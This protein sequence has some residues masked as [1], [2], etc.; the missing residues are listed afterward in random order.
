MNPPR[1]FELLLCLARVSLR[2]S[3]EE[4]EFAEVVRADAEIAAHLKVDELDAVFDLGA[5]TR[6]VDVVFDR[7]SALS[8]RG[9]TIY[10]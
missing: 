10:A 5:Y 1:E 2:A 9:V 3:D 7:L 8:Q 4:Q 6:H